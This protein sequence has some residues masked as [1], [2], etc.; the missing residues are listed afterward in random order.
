MINNRG[1]DMAYFDGFSGEVDVS[2]Q[3]NA[4]EVL[5][6]EILVAA[7]GSG[8]YC[9][10][11]YVLAAKDGKLFEVEGGHCSC[12][13]LEGQWEPGEIS[14]AYLLQR[15]SQGSVLG[16]YVLERGHDALLEAIRAVCES[17]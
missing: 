6:Y 8:D 5:D 14:V 2:N 9:G 13:G 3:F 15:L 16:G 17:R 10:A 4:P 1:R 11:A 12:Y 7:Y